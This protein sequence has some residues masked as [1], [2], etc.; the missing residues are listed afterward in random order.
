LKNYL[1]KINGTEIKTTKTEFLLL[2]YI[3]EKKDE[4][5]LR[6]NLMKDIM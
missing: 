2:K 5:I 6:E 3:I 1:L 4:V